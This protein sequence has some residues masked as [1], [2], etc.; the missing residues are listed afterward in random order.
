[1][2]QIKKTHCTLDDSNV[3]RGAAD[4]F[5]KKYDTHYKEI[6]KLQISLRKA[7][8]AKDRDLCQ[9]LVDAGPAIQQAIKDTNKDWCKMTK[10]QF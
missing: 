5:R 3:P 6:K 8:Q 2:Q 7:L 4:N 1:M 10:I 9:S